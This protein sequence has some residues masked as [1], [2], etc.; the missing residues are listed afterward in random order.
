M[1]GL[2]P[3]RGRVALDENTAVV[4]HDVVRRRLVVSVRIVEEPEEFVNVGVAEA[5]AE[6]VIVRA[7]ALTEVVFLARIAVRRHL[8]QIVVRML[9]VIRRNDT[10]DRISDSPQKRRRLG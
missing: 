3:T 9:E 7:G 6:E 10:I 8:G 4:V 5:I 1:E 2:V